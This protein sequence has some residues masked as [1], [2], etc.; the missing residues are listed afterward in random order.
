[1]RQ[2]RSYCAA[3][4]T[5]ICCSRTRMTAACSM[6]VCSPH[7]IILFSYNVEKETRSSSRACIIWSGHVFQAGV[8]E[9]G[10]NLVQSALSPHTQTLFCC[11]LFRCF[12]CC[13]QCTGKSSEIKSVIYTMFCCYHVLRNISSWSVIC[14]FVFIFYCKDC[15]F[16][17]TKKIL[18]TRE[19]VPLRISLTDY[20]DHGIFHSFPRAKGIVRK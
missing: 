10:I 2:H 4:C 5:T 19:M 16:R 11:S 17:M 1:M 14:L 7:V 12:F 18:P 9:T 13:F 8:N 6:S 20:F 3:W 15:E